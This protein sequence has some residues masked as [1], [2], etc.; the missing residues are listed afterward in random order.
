MMSLSYEYKKM[1]WGRKLY[2]GTD[3]AMVLVRDGN[4]GSG[5]AHANEVMKVGLVGGRNVGRIEGRNVSGEGMSP[6]HVYSYCT[7]TTSCSP[8][9][10][11]PRRA[12]NHR[13]R[14]RTVSYERGSPHSSARTSTVLVA[15]RY[16]TILRSRHQGRLLQESR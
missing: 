9:I 8:R 7:K 4:V 3:H 11:P 10:T 5:G 15:L 2:M 12:S 6:Q 13:T 1:G 16:R 14:T